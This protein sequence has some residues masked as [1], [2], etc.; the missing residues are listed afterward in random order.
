M[1]LLVAHS[2]GPSTTLNA[3]LVGLVDACRDEG[4]P[5]EVH[6]ARRGVDGVLSGDWA[7][8]S[9][10]SPSSLESIM[11]APGSVI[12]TSRRGLS[13]EEAGDLVSELQRRGVQALVLTGGNGS[14]ATAAMLAT[15]ASERRS[16]LQVI[17]LP[18]TVDN[19]VTCTDHTPG[20]ASA[21][22][23][24]AL[25]VRDIDQDNRALPSPITVIETIGRNAGWVAA[26]TALA[27]SGSNDGPH[28]IYLPEHALDEEQ[29][30][31]DARAAVKSWGRAVI[32]AC[33]G[34]RD[35]DGKPFGA[36]LDRP[37]SPHAELARN[38]AHS[39]ARKVQA[40]TGIRARAER[41][42]LL[43]RSCSWALSEVDVEESYRSGRAAAEAAL[44]GATG[45]LVSLRRQP[46][47]AYRSFAHT[48]PFSAEPGR[49]RRLPSEWVDESGAGATEDYLE[50]VR[51][52]VG[53]IPPFERV[54]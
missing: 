21:A 22:R 33:E 46:G 50:W 25:A 18:N 36:D 20:F 24:F 17:G 13:R 43:G 9:A 42:G 14:M 51:P 34:V 15:A 32:V 53:E 4:E 41:P 39:L 19:D 28:L 2:G 3:G 10:V 37:G 11:R 52:L 16:G 26:A 5:I 29:V 31:E 1:K 7:E 45:V 38:L 12:G 35:S 27:R 49:E 6:G 40:A 8:L 44:G 23:F 54:F 30:I 48:V 47:L